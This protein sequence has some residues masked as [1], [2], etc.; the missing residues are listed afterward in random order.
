MSGKIVFAL[1]IIG[2]LI[3]IGICYAIYMSVNSVKLNV[4]KNTKEIVINSCDSS[5]RYL[6]ISGYKQLERIIVNDYACQNVKI[7]VIKNNPKL[8]TITTGYDSFYSTTSLTLSSI[9]YLMF[10]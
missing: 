4:G 7:V 5:K 10:I 3:L 2:I 9:F 8:I 1:S 6:T